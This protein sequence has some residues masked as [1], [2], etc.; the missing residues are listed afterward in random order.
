MT[1]IE[2]A[3]RSIGRDANT[4]ARLVDALIDYEQLPAHRFTAVRDEVTGPIVDALHASVEIVRKQL[5][6]GLRFEFLYRSKIARDF[7]MSVPAVPDHVWEPQTTKLLLHFARSAREVIVGGAYFGDQ[8]IPIADALRGRGV[9]HA[10]EPDPDQAAMLERNAELNGLTNVRVDG[11]GLWGDSRSR[12]AFVGEDAVARTVASQE[13]FATTTIDD[14]SEA[15]GIAADLIMLDLEG[16]E[17]DV[18]RGAERQL[19]QNSPHLVF[20]VHR[21]YVDWT[22]GLQ[23]TKIVRYLTALGYTA[24]AIRDFQS[25]YDL[26]GRPIEL[27]PVETAWLDGP[28]HGFNVVAVRDPAIL[29]GAPFRITPAVSPKLLLHRDAALHHPC[30]GL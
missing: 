21:A 20:E 16:S 18:L 15:S 6:T 9:C 28:P 14:Y 22:A 25:N 11:R 24:F 23:N 19:A 1:T 12:L 4:R 17:L 13:G 29:A 8:A 30:G 27:V 26:A 7:V 2:A 5:S 10:F 3:L